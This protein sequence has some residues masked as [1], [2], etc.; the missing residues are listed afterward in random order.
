MT[1]DP[2]AAD[3]TISIGLTD[4]VTPA[5]RAQIAADELSPFDALAQQ[6]AQPAERKDLLTLKIKQRQNVALR[7]DP[8]ITSEDR[9]IWRNRAKERP[10]GNRA[11][12]RAL[13]GDDTEVDPF[14]FSC[15]AIA[16]TNTAVL[17]NGQEVRLDGQPLTLRDERL[18]QMMKQMSP[19]A[20]I[21][22]LYGNDSHIENTAGEIILASGIDDEM[23]EVDPTAGA[24]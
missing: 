22:W 19:E 20:A 24:S 15:L 9:K 12:R 17:M 13:T 23:E 6:L 1:A 5:E 3:D 8:N 7:F 11:R 18:W 2:A 14:L 10:S 21:K 16:H 4:P